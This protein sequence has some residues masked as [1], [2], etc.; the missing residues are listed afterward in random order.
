MSDDRHHALCLLK[1]LEKA[2]NRL[3]NTREQIGVAR[4]VWCVGMPR[5]L[6]HSSAQLPAAYLQVVD[7]YDNPRNVGSFNKTDTDVGTGLVGAPA[8]GDVMKLQLRVRRAGSTPFAAV[9]QG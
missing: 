2:R 8:C 3:F 5:P 9:F 6:Q 1:R 4:Q 7:H